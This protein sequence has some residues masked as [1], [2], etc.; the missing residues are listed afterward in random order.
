MHVSI[1]V[2]KFRSSLK[3]LSSTKYSASNITTRLLRS[4][5]RRLTVKLARKTLHF[6]EFSAM[7]SSFSSTV[8]RTSAFAI[9]YMMFRNRRGAPSSI[10]T[11][12]SP[13]RRVTNGDGIGHPTIWGTM[14]A[15]IFSSSSG[16]TLAGSVLLFG[17]PIS[18]GT[19]KFRMDM[20][21]SSIGERPSARRWQSSS[22]GAS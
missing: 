13:R 15:L 6:G 3:S 12:T 1:K 14:Y 18:N 16:M 9:M 22:L 7:Q 4:S 2:D 5:P 20:E 21:S 11:P 8:T 10:I 17:R 19:S